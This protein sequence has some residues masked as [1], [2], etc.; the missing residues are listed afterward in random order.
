MTDNSTPDRPEPVPTPP[1]PAA[2]PPAPP[3]PVTTTDRRARA[4][5]RVPA[6]VAVLA[7]LLAGG[8]VAWWALGKDDEGGGGDP[9]EH[10][11]VSDGEFVVD[12][13]D[14]E[15]CDDTDIYSYNDC[16]TDPDETYEF[17]YEIT[18]KGDG[19][20]NYS[21]IV[22]AFDDDG[23]FVGQTY[24]GATHLKPGRTESDKGEFSEYSTLEDNRE[25]SD[26][27]SVKVAHAERTPLA[28]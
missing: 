25:L 6:V 5:R 24:V 16:D 2:P 20:A 9:L 27:A 28:N 11:E 4:G 3:A 21:V 8:G 18:N 7:L 1:Y 15:Y 26:I 22:N 23:D 19:P 14:S 17:A 12:D 13:S 10:V